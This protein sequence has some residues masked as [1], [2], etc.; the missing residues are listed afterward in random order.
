MTNNFLKYTIFFTIGVVILFYLFSNIGFTRVYNLLSQ[1]KIGYFFLAG[2]FYFIAEIIAAIAIKI[3]LKGKMRLKEVFLSH[4]AGMLVSGVTPGRVGYYYTALSLSKK[5]QNSAFGNAGVLT[6]IQ[7]MNFLAKVILCLFSLVYFSSFIIDLRFYS[8]L[9]LVSILPVIFVVGIILVLYTDF[10]NKILAKFKIFHKA[11]Q[12]IEAMQKASKEIEKKRM[13]KIVLLGFIGWPVASM[14]WFFIGTSLG[15]EI[16][17]VNALMLQP[18]VTTLMFIP[19]APAG[20][21][22]AE[23]GSVL[24]FKIVGYT[25]AAGA[26]FLILV[27]LNCILVDSLGLMDVKNFSQKL[28]L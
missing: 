27:R 8:W 14:Q 5:S 9:T 17:F 4:L 20:L 2:F 12:Y 1:I 24:L 23:G 25:T 19:L 15:L 6:L 11:V 18:L 10:L 28:S 16:P 22:F 21:G 7:G 26:V 3:A 13:L